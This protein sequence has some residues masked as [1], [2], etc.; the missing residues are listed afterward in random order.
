MAEI[1]RTG[2]TIEKYGFL[3][4]KV[5]RRIFLLFVL[6]AVLPVSLLA[7]LSFSHVTKQL[8]RQALR[9]LHHECKAA[10]LTIIERFFF[11]ETDL[12]MLVSNHQEGKEGP[13][14]LLT[15][16][17]RNRL[18]E[19]FQSL[20]LLN[21]GY[22]VHPLLGISPFSLEMAEGM[23]DQERLHIAAGKSL[24]R[25][26][27]KE[28]GGADLFMIRAVNPARPNGGLLVGEIHPGY[29]WGGEGFVSAET[30]LFVT[31]SGGFRPLC[32]P[33]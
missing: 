10:G 2:R 26:R 30:E 21:G 12:K 23:T 5:A 13:E 7:V 28:G 1:K 24:V 20:V 14:T 19:R 11:L 22:G 18:S 4:S 33:E 9:R 3:R 15:D 8:H 27:P 25:I 6:C 29:L 31:R 32:H 17:V 16:E